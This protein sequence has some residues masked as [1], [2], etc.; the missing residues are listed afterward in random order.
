MLMFLAFSNFEIA[1]AVLLIVTYL[2]VKKT[3]EIPEARQQARLTFSQKFK[4]AG[5]SFI[6][7]IFEFTVSIFIP[8]FHHGGSVGTITISTREYGNGNDSRTGFAVKPGVT[9]CS[10]HGTRT[11]RPEESRESKNSGTS[12]TR[13]ECSRTWEQSD[14]ALTSAPPVPKNSYR[15]WKRNFFMDKDGSKPEPNPDVVR[16]RVLENQTFFHHLQHATTM[17]Y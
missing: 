1:R 12:I 7:S 4:M 5:K 8:P 11:T 15:Q 3:R 9:D 13:T 16:R 14:A 10:R 6:H 2:R 17:V